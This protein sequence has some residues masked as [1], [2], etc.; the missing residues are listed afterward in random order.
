MALA[1]AY[2]AASHGLVDRVHDKIVP[3]LK[4][5]PGAPAESAA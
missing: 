4:S 5:M 2:E 3:T 1:R